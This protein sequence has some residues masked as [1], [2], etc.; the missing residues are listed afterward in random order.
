MSARRLSSRR[1]VE[2]RE[3]GLG[4]MAMK[5]K[6]FRGGYRFK[7][8]KGR[9]QEDLV[10]LPLPESVAIPLRQGF[11]DE[12]SPVV[13]P[14]DSVRAGQVV[15]RD[16]DGISSPV[17]AG[18][19]GVVK[20]IAE[21]DCADGKTNAVTIESDGA[22]DRQVLEGSSS[23]WEELSA[24]KIED[25]L[26]ESGVASLGRGGIP[27]RH[28]S[29][30]ILPG[31]VKDLIVH[32]VGSE[33]Y[34][35]SPSV[36]L[37]G[38]GTK[39]FVEGVRIL[40]KVMPDARV[41]VALDNRHRNVADE[42]SKLLSAYAWAEVRTLDAVYPQGCDE[43][44]VPALSGREFPHGYSAAHIG[45]VVLDIQAALHAYEAVAEGKPLIE[46]TVALCGPGFIETPHV[47]VR[48]GTPMEH[49]LGGRARED[50]DLR[51]VLD[52]ALTGPAVRDLSAPVDRTVSQVIA[53]PEERTR[54]LIAW[55]RPGFDEDSY[56]R[57]FL[58]HLFP[59]KK[60]ADTNLKGELRPCLSCGWCQE[61]C[62]VGIIPHL[63]SKYAER[64]IID[65]TLVA[66]KIF[67]CIECSLCSYV[68]P[69]KVPVAA[70]IKKGKRKLL[71]DGIDN[72]HSVQGRSDFKVLD[73]HRGSE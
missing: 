17:H 45:A 40:K 67:N 46:R 10:E 21:V 24:E 7:R 48:V 18:V 43:L 4:P 8:F 52:S 35:L 5:H 51:I 47:K 32:G 34:N 49:V 26:Y 59:M 53:L 14:G 9:P 13:A 61:V 3:A 57:A 12:V 27:T 16:D 28:R 73:D 55:L 54:H 44:L 15:G 56:A 33:I 25:L 22:S 60:R 62:P 41:H 11:R 23:D 63:I 42:V 1:T 72:A 36:L 30:L 64:D 69:S 38:E 71:E 20:E 6:R 29:A 39:R 68:C 19:A 70:N 37:G 66:Y 65:E 58:S 2:R 31:D 50:T